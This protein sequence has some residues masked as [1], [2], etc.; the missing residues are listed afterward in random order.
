MID[1][2]WNSTS[3]LGNFLNP[4]YTAVRQLAPMPPSSP[5][6]TSMSSST[7]SQDSDL[8]FP[9]LTQLFNSSRPSTARL[10]KPSQ[11]TPTE[12]LS[13]PPLT[14]VLSFPLHHTLATARLTTDSST[15][16]DHSTSPAVIAH[17][18]TRTPQRRHRLRANECQL[19]ARPLPAGTSSST[20][21]PSLSQPPAP[22]FPLHISV[23]TSSSST[24]SSCGNAQPPPIASPSARAPT[25]I[26]RRKS[27]GR[28]C[29]NTAVINLD[30]SDDE[31]HAGSCPG[32]RSISQHRSASP[33]VRLK[34]MGG[35]RIVL[36]D[37]DSTPSHHE[38]ESSS[39]SLPGRPLSNASFPTTLDSDDEVESLLLTFSPSS[40]TTPSPPRRPSSPDAVHQDDSILSWSPPPRRPLDLPPMHKPARAPRNRGSVVLPVLDTLSLPTAAVP[41]PTPRRRIKSVASIVTVPTTAQRPLNLNSKAWKLRREKL[42]LDLIAELDEKL[43]CSRLSGP[44]GLKGGERS[45][46][47]DIPGV[48]AEEKGLVQRGVHWTGRL[49]TTAGM[50]RW[51]RKRKT[52][53]TVMP[54]RE[55]GDTEEWEHFCRIELSSKVYNS[56]AC[57]PIVI[58]LLSRLEMNLTDTFHAFRSWPRTSPS[59]QLPHMSSCVSSS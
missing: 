35:R 10:T 18:T 20:A 42:S 13:P 1:T 59:W 16:S 48:E 44:L 15:T 14:P 7:D 2:R 8:E 31:D 19:P 5:S 3:V 27:G 33:P 17:V 38:T 39:L 57:F 53:Q 55:D 45:L 21:Q 41:K 43:F 9:T 40:V 24:A 22:S 50:S 23:S 46:T 56:F 36:S 4:S 37:S 28:D 25:T 52:A 58:R 29:L 47:T 32:P 54:D 11:T 6:Y 34:K 30:S 51:C 49:R 26:D 12:A